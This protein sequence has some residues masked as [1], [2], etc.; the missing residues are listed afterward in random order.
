MKVFNVTEGVGKLIVH[1]D[2]DNS[3]YSVSYDHGNLIFEKEDRRYVIPETNTDD[4]FFDRIDPNLLVNKF[5]FSSYRDT[6]RDITP[7]TFNINSI[8]N[9]SKN[10]SIETDEITISGINDNLPVVV[11][12][13]ITLY[14]NGVVKDS[15]SLITN[16]DIVKFA[17][18]SASTGDT[19]DN[20]NINFGIINKSFSIQTIPDPAG[21]EFFITTGAYNPTSPNSFSFSGNTMTQHNSTT[22]SHCYVAKGSHGGAYIAWNYDFRP[23]IGNRNFKLTISGGDTASYNGSYVQAFSGAPGSFENSDCYAAPG[24]NMG[25][26]YLGGTNVIIE[27]S[28][29]P[30]YIKFGNVWYPSNSDNGDQVTIKIEGV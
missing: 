18:T 2:G 22:E 25:G 5:D 14:I 17:C 4:L 10:T 24:I 13:G 1:M 12:A 8:S 9:A 21:I 30:I 20:Y 28:S 3:N 6:Y 15:G 11:P 23:L 27:D 26:E 16:G 29:S 7:D 19:T